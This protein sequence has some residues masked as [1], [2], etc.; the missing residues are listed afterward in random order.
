[1]VAELSIKTFLKFVYQIKHMKII[2]TLIVL[3][4]IIGCTNT[5]TIHKETPNLQLKNAEWF[6][7]KWENR[8]G[9]GIMGEE[10]IK[11]NDSTFTGKGY[12]LKNAD[13]VFSE[14]LLLSVINDTLYYI[15]VVKDQNAGQPVYFKLT[16]ASNNLLVFENK[17]HDFPQLIKYSKITSDS[18]IAEISG[19]LNGKESIRQ[20]PMN[21]QK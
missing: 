11:E 4:M 8:T 2:N 13:T 17:K 6:L 20:F 18:I 10:W 14:K 16:S 15:P 5:P 19:S 1:M 21:R 9:D 7:G 3:S 12:V